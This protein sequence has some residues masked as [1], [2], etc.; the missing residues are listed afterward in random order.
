MSRICASSTLPDNANSG[1][2]ESKE[3]DG[4]I[5]GTNAVSPLQRIALSL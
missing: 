4:V 1:R 2:A 5:L 3:L